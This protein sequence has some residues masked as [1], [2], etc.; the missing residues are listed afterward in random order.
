M[1]TGFL[2]PRACWLLLYCYNLQVYSTGV[3]PAVTLGKLV[4]YEAGSLSVMGLNLMLP[5]SRFC[6]F[7]LFLLYNRSL[8]KLDQYGLDGT[9]SECM[10]VCPSG[11][12]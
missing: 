3:R 5:L 10:Q 11:S 2:W 4:M 7:P 6:A 12:S 8:R 1:L 9:P